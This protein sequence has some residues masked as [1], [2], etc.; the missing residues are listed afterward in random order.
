MSW[1]ALLLALTACTSTPTRPLAELRGKEVVLGWSP[2][3]TEP[4][5]M[6]LFVQLS[7]QVDEC[8]AVDATATLDGERLEVIERGS[9]GEDQHGDSFCARPV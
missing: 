3:R 6:D 4:E 9:S 8:V 7:Y 2:V 1:R 5:Q